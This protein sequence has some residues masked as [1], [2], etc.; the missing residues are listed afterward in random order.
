M[1]ISIIFTPFKFV[2]SLGDRLKQYLSDL[3]DMAP[4]HMRMLTEAYGGGKA[5]ENRSDFD[6]REQLIYSWLAMDHAYYGKVSSEAARHWIMLGDLHSSE[7]YPASGKKF[8]EK[9]VEILRQLNEGSVPENRLFEALDKLAVCYSG[10][11]RPEDARTLYAEIVSMRKE[12]DAESIDSL[13]KLMQSHAVLGEFDEAS[14]V[15]AEILESVESGTLAD[16]LEGIAY[17]RS[18]AEYLEKAGRQAE[19]KEFAEIAESLDW[20]SIIFKSCGRDSRQLKTELE[21]LMAAY[22]RRSRGDIVFEIERDIRIISLLAATSDSHSPSLVTDLERL[23]ELLEARNLG[24]D[25]TTA[26]HS[27][28][29]AKRVL[30]KREGRTGIRSLKAMLAGLFV[31]THSMLEALYVVAYDIG[32]DSWIALSAFV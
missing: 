11:A 4:Y 32:L 22:R 30:E 16:C 21:K 5:G 19:A 2:F 23:A 10:C 9:A 14:R 28:A 6:R 20:Y 17:Y 31:S 15:N 7:R 18:M 8:Y 3:Q 27:R 12:A 24:G 1:K 26:F 25:S 29:R 13:A